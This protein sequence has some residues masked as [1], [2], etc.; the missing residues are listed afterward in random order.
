MGSQSNALANLADA[1]E[2]LRNDGGCSLSPEAKRDRGDEIGSQQNSGANSPSASTQSVSTVATDVPVVA[3]ST[4][5]ASADMNA[6]QQHSPPAAGT[7]YRYPPPHHHP[8]HHPHYSPSPYA[9]PPHPLPPPHHHPHFAYHRP[10]APVPPASIMSM[11]PNPSKVTNKPAAASSGSDKPGGD[12]TTRDDVET[13][14]EGAGDVDMS[15]AKSS[16]EDPQAIA[17][18]EENTVKKAPT[19]PSSTGAPFY[20]HAPYHH[21]AGHPGSPHHLYPYPPAHYAPRP[22]PPHR[23]HSYP[24]PPPPRYPYPPSAHHA[25]VHYPAPK[26]YY[27]SHSAGTY[28]Y[29]G[30]TAPAPRAAPYSEVLKSSPS[31]TPASAT[32]AKST[33]EAS[34]RLGPSKVSLRPRHVTEE[35]VAP[36]SKSSLASL[37]MAAD[38]DAR[39]SESVPQVTPA[40]HIIAARSSPQVSSSMVEFTEETQFL[41]S[42]PEYKRRASTG[43]WTAEED[44]Q[45]R[46]AVNANSGKNWKKIAVHLPGRTDVQCLHRWQKVLKPGLVK[47]PWTPQEDAMVVELVQKYGQKK[48]S[49]IARQLH[50]RLGKQ[51]RERWYNHLSPDSE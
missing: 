50:G 36:T 1:A 37:T 8:M 15:D 39:T 25:H 5:T 47:G 43:K 24:G 44:A 49:F 9:Y 12:A 34:P 30:H 17:P 51:C 29:P 35:D 31:A 38:L 6:S 28:D 48:W 20:A 21:L 42:T 10:P 14:K 3:T 18:E 23:M 4:P 32:D 19:S 2:A 22:P 40:K 41:Q 27:R 7:Y 13:M 45:L 33:V 46:Q 16:K 11:H 26:P